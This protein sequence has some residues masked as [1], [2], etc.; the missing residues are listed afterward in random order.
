[1]QQDAVTVCDLHISRELPHVRFRLGI[2]NV[3]EVLNHITVQGQGVAKGVVPHLASELHRSGVLAVE[4]AIGVNR[5][6][7]Q[8]QT[9]NLGVEQDL[10]R[11]I[12]GHATIDIHDAYVHR[13]DALL[14]F[15][16]GGEAT[17]GSNLND[18]AIDAELLR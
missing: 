9:R 4:D 1:T 3:E 11:R 5:G 17:V 18:L 2:V 13:S 8:I 7:G 14:Q 12:E 6:F 16:G 15:D 10:Q